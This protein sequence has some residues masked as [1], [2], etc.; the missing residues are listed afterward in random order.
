MMEFERDTVPAVTIID[1]GAEARN[2]FG[3]AFGSQK[4]NLTPDMVDALK[5][6]KQLAIDIMDGEYVLFLATDVE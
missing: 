3:H 6:G 1:G 5:Q 2:R 4:L